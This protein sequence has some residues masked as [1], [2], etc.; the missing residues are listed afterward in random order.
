MSNFRKTSGLAVLAALGTFSTLTPAAE[1][2][3]PAASA[4]SVVVSYSHT[5]L[6][7]AGAIEALYRQFAVA[8]ERACGSYEPRNLRQREDWR[9]CHEAAV[10]GAIARF[11]EARIVTL[12]RLEFPANAVSVPLA[13]ARL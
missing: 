9:R 5:D 2:A 7:S 12:D 3:Q 11:V 4:R 6:G 1:A 8:A 13:A 10:G